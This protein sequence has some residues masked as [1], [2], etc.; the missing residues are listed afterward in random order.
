MFE[1]QVVYRG[2]LVIIDV[3]SP[4]FVLT[5]DWLPM[6]KHSLFRVWMV[7]SH[8]TLELALVQNPTTSNHCHQV[9]ALMAYGVP[10]FAPVENLG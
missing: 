9:S 3:Y 5:Y 7:T 1:D 8:G 10:S 2:S 4:R 6:E